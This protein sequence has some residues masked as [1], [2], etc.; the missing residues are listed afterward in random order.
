MTGTKKQ[1]T[2]TTAELDKRMARNEAKVHFVQRM[3][4]H[5]KNNLENCTC[6]KLIW[7]KKGNPI[8]QRSNKSKPSKGLK[9]QS[10]GK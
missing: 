5:G 2:E 6:G 10:P 9:N 1:Q 8:L 3:R 4:E 7:R